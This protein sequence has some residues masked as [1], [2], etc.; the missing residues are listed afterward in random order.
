MQVGI[1]FNI[2]QMVEAY[3]KN[4]MGSFILIDE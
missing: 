4:K 2:H 1:D 3:S